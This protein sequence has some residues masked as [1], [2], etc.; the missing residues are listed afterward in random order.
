MKGVRIFV[1][2]II[3]MMLL[4]FCVNATESHRE[5]IDSSGAEELYSFLDDSTKDALN[6]LGIG[7]VNFDSV[8]DVSFSK[9]FSLVKNSVSGA[10]DSPLKALTKLICIIILICIAQS[11]VPE[12][13]DYEK[14]FNVIGV[15]FSISVIIAP[16]FQAV[17]ASVSSMG[18][19]GGF[20]KGLI[21][22][23]TG[24]VSASG[25]PT[26][27]ISFQSAAFG[28]AQ[29][30]SVIGDNYAVPVISGIMALDIAGSLMPGFRLS[31]I[32]D[33]IKKTL[34]SVMSFCATLYVSF[35]GLKG[36]LSNA[37]DT[38]ASKGIK[39]II[40]SAVPVVG[41]AVSE[42]YSGILG[43]LILVRSTIGIFGMIAIALIM[44]PSMIQLIFWIFALKAGAAVSEI[45]NLGSIASLMKALSSVLTLFNVVLLFNGV[46]FII[47]LALIVTIRQ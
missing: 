33:L 34:I 15:L 41:G 45:F 47:S 5:L 3:F 4:T 19:C 9:I 32:T 22:V 1:M 40:S 11:F 35:L 8:F 7:S 21:P 18:V 31:G 44:M 37:A 46:L 25:N 23:M 24:V 30:M 26:L 36:A 38:V 6:E 2:A 16:V 43:S 14:I 39:L 27:A 20:M 10:V 12:G 42:A 13:G 17:E 28:A 29:I